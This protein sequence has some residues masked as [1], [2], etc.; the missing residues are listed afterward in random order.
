MKLQ[1]L[2]TAAAEG[3]P[4]LFCRCEACQR[5]KKLGGKN[6]RT[7]SQSLLDDKLLID[8]PADT[9]LHMLAHQI[10]LPAVEHI[11]ITHSHEDHFYP[12]ELINKIPPYA[13]GGEIP[14]IYVH[15]NKTVIGLL[16]Q[17]M[18]RYGLAETQPYL[19]P[20][21]E[22]PFTP[23]QAGEYRVIPLLANHTP[24]EQCFLYSVEREGKRLL[25]AHDT[26]NLPAE[27][28]QF[29]KSTRF[30][31]VS[32]DCT[33]GPKEMPN[34][35]MGLPNNVRLKTWMLEQGVADEN[36]I[37]VANHFSHNAGLCHEEMCEAAQKFG[38][39]VSYD[40]MILQF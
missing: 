35:H 3:W 11:L 32:M 15:G 23:F 25:Y 5:A 27:T 20:V 1:F 19:S 4:A 40:G 17:T 9:Y 22:K 33:E 28:L 36:T 6:I 12:Q 16:Q 37:F 24:A 34:W 18:E 30:D 29:L 8:L 13:Y 21:E 39:L 10:D 31:A 2:G 26:G 38:I 14:R 7:R